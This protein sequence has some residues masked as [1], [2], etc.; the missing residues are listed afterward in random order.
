MSQAI[1]RLAGISLLGIMLCT[2]G[3][4]WLLQFYIFVH[5]IHLKA[6]HRLSQYIVCVCKKTLD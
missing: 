6:L 5:R 4:L 2:A 1:Y 3:I